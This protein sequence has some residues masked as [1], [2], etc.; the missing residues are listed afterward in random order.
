M[1]ETI[2]GSIVLILCIF[3]VF[4]VYKNGS[5]DAYDNSNNYVLNASFERIDGI[6]LGSSVMISGINVGKVVGQNLDTSSY[7]A[8]LKL[9]IHGDIKLPVDTSAEIVSNGLLGDKYIALIPGADSESLKDG[10]YVEF[11]QSSIS[12]ENLISK[13]VFGLEMQQG[14]KGEDSSLE[15]ENEEEGSNLESQ[16]K[17]SSTANNSTVHN[18]SNPISPNNSSNH[19]ESYSGKDNKTNPEATPDKSDK[20]LK[21]DYNHPSNL[22]TNSLNKSS[23]SNVDI[24]SVG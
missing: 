3:F 11:T 6:A 23:P 19:S 9:S 20:G 5:L 8:I 1:L 14:K 17:S 22:E 15:E 10:D 12:I 16:V 18:S 2:V 7:N 13:M 24:I 21:K 4:I